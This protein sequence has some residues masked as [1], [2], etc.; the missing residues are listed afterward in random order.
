MEHISTE[1]IKTWMHHHIEDIACGVK[2]TDAARRKAD[3]FK[4]ELLRRHLIA[5]F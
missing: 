4:L 1:K 5:G 2:V 3:D